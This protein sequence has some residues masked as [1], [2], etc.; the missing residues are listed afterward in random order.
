[1]DLKFKEHSF[2]FCAK[3]HSGKSKSGWMSSWFYG[4]SGLDKKTACLIGKS[5]K[6]INFI[7]KKISDRM[8]HSHPVFIIHSQLSKLASPLPQNL[9]RGG[10]ACSCLAGILESC[11]RK[12]KHDNM[13]T[14]QKVDQSFVKIVSMLWQNDSVLLQL[15]I[16]WEFNNQTYETDTNRFS[17]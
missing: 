9:I 11:R 6:W 17:D 3:Y 8:E 2:T 15:F 14:C 13:E 1:M 5:W 16:S 7:C 12:S 4:A 10:P